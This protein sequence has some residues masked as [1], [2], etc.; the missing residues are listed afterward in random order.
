LSNNK[1]PSKYTQLND[2]SWL[3]CKYEVEGLST[4]RIGAIVGCSNPTVATALRYANIHVRSNSE[5][6]KGPLGHF[7][8]KCHTDEAKRK[9][10]RFGENNPM[11]GKTHKKDTLEKMCQ[12][13]RSRQFPTHHT[14]PELQFE[15]ICTKYNLPFRYTG[16]S[17]LWI[18]CGDK[19]LNPDFVGTNGN[20]NVVVE[21][22]GDWFHDPTL[23]PK[24]RESATYEYRF[25]HFKDAGYRMIVFWGSE[26]ETEQAERLVLER[27]GEVGG[28]VV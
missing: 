1:M 4:R 5:S 2:T 27:L 16:D 24:V 3:S 12:K 19:K 22:F 21:I 15:A 18:G 23:N 14:K 17:A 7:F 26:L 25:N 8:G 10:Q 9:V 28:G 20:K 6:Q 13:R 11:W